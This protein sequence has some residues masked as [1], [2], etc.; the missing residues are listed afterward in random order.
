MWL[1]IL[2][3]I[4]ACIYILISNCLATAV[5]LFFLGLSCK[6]TRNQPAAYVKDHSLHAQYRKE[7]GCFLHI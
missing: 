5:K 3:Y 1:V 4:N 6:K 7:I 2:K